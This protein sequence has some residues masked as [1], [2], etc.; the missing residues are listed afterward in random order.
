MPWNDTVL[1]NNSPFKCHPF[2]RVLEFMEARKICHQ[3]A[4]TSICSIPYSELCN[5]NCIETSET[6]IIWSA[7]CYTAGSG[8]WDAIKGVPDRL[9]KR[10]W[11]W[12]MAKCIHVHAGKVIN[13][14]SSYTEWRQLACSAV[15]VAYYWTKAI[16]I[17]TPDYRDTTGIYHIARRFEVDLSRYFH[18]GWSQLFSK[19]S[20]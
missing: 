3:V 17:L 18:V 14:T 4:R 12:S 16:I 13:R 19:S 20:T 9:L 8:R 2:S 11:R 5:K 1:N 10:A 6:L 15:Q 7:Y